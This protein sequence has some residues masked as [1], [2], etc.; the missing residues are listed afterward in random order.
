MQI[1]YLDQFADEKIKEKEDK[2]Q[3]L[4]DRVYSQKDEVMKS[5]ILE[6]LHK[7]KMNLN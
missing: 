3:K 5:F 1:A 6:D 2:F 7:N 4:L